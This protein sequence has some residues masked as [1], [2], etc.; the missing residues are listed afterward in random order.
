VSEPSVHEFEVAVEK[1]IRSKLPGKG[2]IPAEQIQLGGK[3]VNSV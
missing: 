2:Q 1:L 3:T